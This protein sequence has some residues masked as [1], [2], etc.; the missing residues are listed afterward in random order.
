M[1]VSTVQEGLDH[2][3]FVG[4]GGQHPE[5]DL[6]EV[7][8][9]EGH[10]VVRDQTCPDTVVT[11]GQLVGWRQRDRLAPGLGGQAANPRVN[12]SVDQGGLDDGVDVGREE[13]ASV[14]GGQ[15][16]T[17]EVVVESGQDVLV[18]LGGP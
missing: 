4:Q 6:G 1:Q 13:L 8:G 12:P 7:G 9:H 15:H 17:G 14:L 10:A 2:V 16:R 3:G 5:L 18:D 11:A